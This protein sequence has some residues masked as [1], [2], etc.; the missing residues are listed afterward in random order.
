MPTYFNNRARDYSSRTVIVN[1]KG[2]DIKL[3]DFVVLFR[4]G[5]VTGIHNEKEVLLKEICDRLGGFDCK[6]FDPY[7]TYSSLADSGLL[8]RVEQKNAYGFGAVSFFYPNKS[9]EQ[10]LRRKIINHMLEEVKSNTKLAAN[11]YIVISDRTGNL[12]LKHL[13]DRSAGDG[14]ND[15]SAAC[16][17]LPAD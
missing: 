13:K 7:M 8:V 17:G 11:G 12:K 5:V 1:K 16:L 14:R 4:P 2:P 9:T 6:I 3:G 15:K 10:D